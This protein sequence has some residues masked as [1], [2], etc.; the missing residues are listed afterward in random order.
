M[1]TVDVKGLSCTLHVI[2]PEAGTTLISLT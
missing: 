2:P 1:K